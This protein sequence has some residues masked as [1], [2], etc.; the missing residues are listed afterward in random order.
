VF[1]PKKSDAAPHNSSQK[2]LLAD[3]EARQNQEQNNV[4]RD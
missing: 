1:I 2:F 4:L 3:R